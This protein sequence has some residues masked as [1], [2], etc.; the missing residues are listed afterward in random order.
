MTITIDKRQYFEIITSSICG[1]LFISLFIFEIFDFNEYSKL[2]ACLAFSLIVI[3]LIY[4]AFSALSTPFTVAIGLSSVVFI[5]A[6]FKILHLRG[7]SLIIMLGSLFEVLAIPILGVLILKKYLKQSNKNKLQLLLFRM[8]T[9]YLIVKLFLFSV[10][11]FYSINLD[12]IFLLPVIFLLSFFTLQD[13]FQGYHIS[14][15]NG[16]KVLLLLHLTLFSLKMIAR[17]SE[18]Y[19][20]QHHLPKIGALY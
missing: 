9:I 4:Y 8:L 6:I 5:G 1:L 10:L 7:Y 19:N 13:D 17:T 16:I 14:V 2:I 3:L 11:K 20:R 18:N 12:F 15:K